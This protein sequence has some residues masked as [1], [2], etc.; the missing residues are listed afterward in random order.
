MTN[1]VRK[2]SVCS[3]LVYIFRF[4]FSAGGMPAVVSFFLLLFNLILAFSAVSVNSTSAS[5]AKIL[6][7]VF[8][9]IP[10]LTAAAA[11]VVAAQG[12]PADTC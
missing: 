6:H 7:Q 1:S 9:G 4:W 10:L 12:W 2:T 5:L 8:E 3:L 11:A